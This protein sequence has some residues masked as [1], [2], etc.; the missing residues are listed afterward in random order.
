MKKMTLAIMML[1]GTIAFAQTTTIIGDNIYLKQDGKFKNVI[2]KYPDNDGAISL[3]KSDNKIVLF[4]N[5]LEGYQ[6]GKSGNVEFVITF[7]KGERYTDYITYGEVLEGL[8]MAVV[9]ENIKDDPAFL[10]SFLSSDYMMI[11]MNGDN[12]FFSLQESTRAYQFLK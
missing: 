1:W 12:Y 6:F 7:K 9:K 2:F 11:D 10:T 4:L 3:A 8:T 5:L